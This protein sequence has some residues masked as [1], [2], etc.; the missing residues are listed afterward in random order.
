M[1]Q[2]NPPNKIFRRDFIEH[3]NGQNRWLG[4]AMLVSEIPAYWFALSTFIIIVILLSFISFA[5]FTRRINVTGEVVSLPHPT[6]IIAPQNGTIVRSYF[7]TGQFVKKGQALFQLDISR[8]SNV[9]NHSEYELQTIKKQ[10]LDSELIIQKL[11]QNKTDTLTNL[12]QQLQQVRQAQHHTRQRYFSAKKELQET[13]QTAQDY[14]NYL[15]RGLVNREQVS[16]LRYL[17]FE[18]Q[19]AVENLFNQLA[20][21]T[22]TIQNLEKEIRNREHELHT[23]ILQQQVQYNELV[24]QQAELNAN[25]LLLIKAPQAGYVENIILQQGQMVNIGDQLLQLSPSQK[26]QFSIILW[27]PNQSIPYIK[28]GDTVNLRYHAFPYEK[29]GQFSGKIEQIARVPATQQELSLYGSAPKNNDAS[30]YKVTIL[31]AKNQISWQ[32][33]QLELSSGMKAEATFF[34]EKRPLYQWILAP[35]YDLQQRMTGAIN[36]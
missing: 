14:Q 8:T 2:Q 12:N 10:M 30:Y 27:L 6:T 13:Q 22:L 24:R 15:K 18:R 7:Q 21:R 28:I 16:Q 35:F 23:Q 11:K 26:S 19:T 20:E 3:I 31:P 29:F 4:H 32:A 34:L 25:H 9:G 36:E 5:Q 17:A 33:Q 1:D